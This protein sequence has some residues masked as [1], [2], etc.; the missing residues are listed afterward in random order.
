MDE[1]ASGGCLLVLCAS[2]SVVLFVP[3]TSSVGHKRDKTT[4]IPLIKIRKS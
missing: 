4:L 3:L 1:A 2:A